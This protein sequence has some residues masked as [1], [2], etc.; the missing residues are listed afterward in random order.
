MVYQAGQIRTVVD[1]PYSGLL[2]VTPN[3]SAGSSKCVCYH[4]Y[5]AAPTFHGETHVV[6]TFARSISL[7]SLQLQSSDQDPTCLN[8]DWITRQSSIVRNI[9]LKLV[10]SAG[11]SNTLGQGKPEVFTKDLLTLGRCLLVPQTVG[12]LLVCAARN[13]PHTERSAI[14]GSHLS[15]L[16][17][18]SK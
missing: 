17:L 4:N 8:A 6:L 10:A 2:F 1:T 11:S 18:N 12:A 14:A 16:Y 15:P 9:G 7:H 5:S 13:L 3:I